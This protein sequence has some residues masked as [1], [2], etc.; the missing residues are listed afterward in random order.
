MMASKDEGR[1][2]YNKLKLMVA[3]FL[4][5]ELILGGTISQYQQATESMQK[6]PA[7]LLNN[8]DPELAAEMQTVARR[9]MNLP[10]GPAKNS[11]D[12][13]N[14]V[15]TNRKIIPQVQYE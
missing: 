14:R 6:L 4:N 15:I 3:K 12:Y 5:V 2:L 11:P 13:F 1:L 10:V 9:L 7:L 8:P